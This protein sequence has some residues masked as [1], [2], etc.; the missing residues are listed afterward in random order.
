MAASMSSIWSKLTR[1]RPPPCL[2]ARFRRGRWQD[3][4]PLA[5]EATVD[6]PL[7]RT[8]GSTI[9]ISRWLQAPLYLGLIVAQRAV[10]HHFVADG[11]G[12]GASAGV[13]HHWLTA[14]G[15]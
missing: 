5:A 2:T 13:R 4:A 11:S 7:A 8:V 14:P 6:R 9:F 1:P 10:S 3:A 15:G 12:G